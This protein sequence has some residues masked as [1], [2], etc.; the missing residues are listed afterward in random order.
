VVVDDQDLH[1]HPENETIWLAGVCTKRSSKRNGAAAVAGLSIAATPCLLASP[2][3]RAGGRPARDAREAEETL[4]QSRRITMQ[5]SDPQKH[6]HPYRR[7][8]AMVAASTVVMFGLMYLNTYRPDHVA[9]IETRAYMALV[10]GA[11]MA[12]IPHHSIAILTSS[13]ARID[14]PRV[15]ALADGIVESQQREIAE[16]QQLVR[17]L[18][19]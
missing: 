14:D 19:R 13:R 15:R 6:A 5:R 2:C 3:T 18:R 4:P 17:E 7:F 12:M 9:F 11:S 1:A 8:I 10:M 16:M